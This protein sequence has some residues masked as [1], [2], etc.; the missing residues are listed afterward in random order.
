ML[1]LR[2][3]TFIKQIK[4]KVAVTNQ[5]QYWTRAKKIAVLRNGKVQNQNE[6]KIWNKSFDEQPKRLE[7]KKGILK[8]E[9]SLYH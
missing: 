4:I 2:F 6:F 5:M 8:G 1:S 3:S 9:V 7:I